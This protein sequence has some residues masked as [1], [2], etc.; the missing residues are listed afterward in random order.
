ML[1]VFCLQEMYVLRTMTHSA[2]MGLI[3]AR[4]FVDVVVNINTDEFVGTLGKL[5]DR[6][7]VV[8]YLCINLLLL[9]LIH[10]ISI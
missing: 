5:T 1:V 4:D 3:S 6:A 2:A 7:A 10:K 9:L 8:V